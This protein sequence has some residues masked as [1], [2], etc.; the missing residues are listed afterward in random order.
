MIHNP[1]YHRELAEFFSEDIQLYERWLK[2]ENQAVHQFW[3]SRIN[4]VGTERFEPALAEAV[5]YK[6]LKNR[7]DSIELHECPSLGGVDFHATKNGNEF[8]CEVTNI[9]IHTATQS[10][11]QPHRLP[12]DI[13]TWTT[14]SITDRIRKKV[15]SKDSQIAKESLPT[16]LFISTFHELAS[17]ECFD[18]YDIEMLAIGQKFWTV[19]KIPGKDFSESQAIAQADIS[20]SIFYRSDGRLVSRDLC[21]LLVSGFTRVNRRVFGIAHPDPPK[22]FS[23]SWLPGVSFVHSHLDGNEIYARRVPLPDL[24]ALLTAQP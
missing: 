12:K 23:P 14:G 11:K 4:A 20:R 21:C 18:S 22:P 15:Q 10:I 24:G 13:E 2:S 7:V 5:S 3:E 6:E 19:P 1:V 16:V 9:S 17:R 8:L